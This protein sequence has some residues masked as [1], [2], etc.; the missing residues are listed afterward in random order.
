MT[1]ST[2]TFRSPYSPSPGSSTPGPEVTPEEAKADIRAFRW[3]A[4]LSTAILAVGGVAGYLYIH[5]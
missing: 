3:V 1:E 5:P 2:E 4:L